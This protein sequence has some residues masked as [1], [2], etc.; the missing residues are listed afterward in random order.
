MSSLSVKQDNSSL[1]H[2]KQ[3]HHFGWLFVVMGIVVFCVPFFNL[4][5]KGDIWVAHA[6]GALFAVVGLLIGLYRLDIKLNLHQRSYHVIKG[7]IPSPKQYTGQLNNEV[8]IHFEK[9]WRSSGNNNKSK[10]LYWQ[11][12][13][14]IPGVKAAIELHEGLD[15]QKAR[16]YFEK[17]AKQLRVNTWDKTGDV[18]VEKNWDQLDEAIKQRVDASTVVRVNE[19]LPPAGLNHETINNGVAYT[20]NTRGVN[21]TT[22]LGALFG[23]PFFCMGLI[24]LCVGLGLHK[25]FAWDITVSGSVAAFFIVGSV[26]TLIG[27]LV[28]KVSIAHAFTRYRFQFTA[29]AFTLSTIVYG[30]EKKQQSLP[31][32]SIEDF[33]VRDSTSSRSQSSIRVGGI[34]VASSKQKKRAELFARSDDEVIKVD[35]INPEQAEYL[36]SVFYQRAV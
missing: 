13:L 4:D 21:A 8:Q 24:S 10:H 30:R 31:L 11:T 1:I 28:I 22:V 7:F 16:Q 18:P 36:N 25:I 17:R 5:T 12:A 33:G 20:N 26:F 15:E 32:S 6:V 29:Q 35:A 19:S 27:G 23:L 9:Q 34:K 14:K 3:N 2:L